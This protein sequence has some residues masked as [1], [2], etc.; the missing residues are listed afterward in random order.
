MNS[1]L[2]GVC[3]GSF[4]A[5][6]LMSIVLGEWLSLGLVIITYTLILYVACLDYIIG[7]Y[8]ED[9]KE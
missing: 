4:I 1:F 7:R 6:S 2:A 5:Y 3:V 9:I 8:Y